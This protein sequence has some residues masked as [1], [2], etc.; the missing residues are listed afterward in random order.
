MDI[1]KKLEMA[2]VYKGMTKAALAQ[3]LD[4]TP[5]NITQKFKRGTFYI[6]DCQKIAEILGAEF[7]FTIKFPDGTII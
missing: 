5:A 6:S 2:L 4:V 7:D 3:A 1:V